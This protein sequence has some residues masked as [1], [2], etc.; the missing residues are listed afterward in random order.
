MSYTQTDLTNKIITSG[1]APHTYSWDFDGD[2]AEMASQGASSQSEPDKIYV[3]NHSYG[4]AAGWQD[5]GPGLPL[6]WYGVW[7]DD[8]S[9]NF[10]KY[11]LLTNF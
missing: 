9:E 7:G 3:S 2:I 4:Y 8:E 6:R 5:Q 1:N 11:V 10:G